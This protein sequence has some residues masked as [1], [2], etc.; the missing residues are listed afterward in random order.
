MFV[1]SGV[2][3]GD[4]CMAASGQLPQLIGYIKNAIGCGTLRRAGGTAVQAVAGL[5]VCEGDVVETAADARI[6]IHFIDGTVL[7]LSGDTCAQL[8]EFAHDC[9]GAPRSALFAISRGNFAFAGGELARSGS[10][11]VDTPVG[12]IR[13]RAGAG[14][15]GMLSLTALVFS[16]VQE[17]RAADPD[18][19]ILDDDRIPYKDLRHGV[20]E[21]ITKEA[22]P[23]HI[24]VE[25]P[26]ETIVLTQRGSAVSINQV[27]NSPAR[28]EELQ[29]AQQ[30]VLA[31][32]EKGWEPKGSGS[33]PSDK[34]QPLLQ[35]INFD[36]A[37]PP[38]AQDPLAPLPGLI[39]PPSDFLLPQPPIL[40]LGAGPTEIDTFAFDAFAT[41]SGT[42]L[43]SAA[44][45]GTL[46]FG[47][48]G[49]I[50]ANEVIGQQTYD[51]S[52]VGAFGTLYLNSATGAYTFVPDD[53]AI[54]ALKV[55]ATQSFMITVSDGKLSAS[56]SFNIPIHGADDAA[57]VSGITTGSA[58]GAVGVSDAS[59]G[60][61]IATGLLTDTDVDDPADTFTAVSSPTK[62]A[63]GY[64]S[65]TMTAGGAWTYTLD[66]DNGSVQALKVG[67]TLIDS[68]TVT[69]IGGT[70]QEV[71]VTIHGPLIGATGTGPPLALSET[72]LTA[73]GLTEISADFSAAFTTAEG[74][75][76]SYALT[77]TGGNGTA[78]GLVDSHTGLADV[79]VLNGGTIEGR[80]G[81]TSGTLAFTITVDPA[82]GLVTFTEYRAVLQPLGVAP[83]DG[84]SVSLPA[85][86]VNLVATL[87]DGN[88][89]FQRASLDLGSR[90]TITDDGP[91][92]AATGAAPSLVL[93]ET[94][95]PAGSVPA[96]ALTTA[97]ADFAAA[98]TSVQ[99]ADG[100]TTGYALTITGGD[101]TAWGL[102][103][104]HTGLADV[105]VLNGNTIE[106][107]VG[108][109]GG[110][111]AFTIALDPATGLVT[112]TEYRAV[113]QLLGTNPD[114]GEGLSLTAGLVNLVATITDTD[115]D[116]QTATLDLGTRL[117]ITDDGPTIG[118]TGTAPA[119][120]LSET[121][122][123]ATAL[124]ES[125]AGSAPDAAL[126][127]ISADFSSA[128]SSVQGADS[129]SIRY[130]LTIT[131]GDGTPS[132]LIDSHSGLAD[133][134]VLN[135]NTVE[136][137]VGS[138][139]GTLAF[140][141]A[142]DP[143]TGLVTFTEYRAVKQ[144]LGTNPDSGEGLSLT[145]GIVNLVA[146]IT[147]KDGD[148]QTAGIDLGKQ[149]T[150]TDDG[151]TIV[152]SGTAPALTLSETHLTDCNDD[153]TG[154]SPNA[155]L[156]AIS[157]DFSSAFASI[158]GA[159]SATTSYALAISCDGIASGLIDSHTGLSDVLIQNGNMIEGRVGCSSGALAFT[160]A[161][162]PATGLVTFTE[163]R[164][165][166]HPL[167]TDPDSG[168][169]TS[170]SAGIIDLVA[171]ITDKDG[172]FQTASIDL[173]KQLTITDDGPT[174]GG[175]K[176]EVIS[177]ESN[178]I[179][180][181]YDVDFGADGHAAMLLAVHNGAVGSTGFDLA[182]S[183]LGDGI[184]A[185]HVTGNDADYTFF[186]TTCEVNG[187]VELKAYL[188]NTDG[189]LTDPYFKLVISPDGTYCFD[190]Q[191][192]EVLNEVTV[193]GA[194][195][196]ASGGH[197]PSLTSPDGQLNITGSTSSGHPLDVKASGNGIA[198]GDYGL[199]MDPCEQ[200]DLSFGQEQSQVSFI[201]TQ[202]QGHGTAN[203]T[204]TAID[205]GNEVHCF[206]INVPKP[207]GDIANIVV[208]ET[209][210]ASLIDT[211]S[212]DGATSTYTLYVGHQFDQIQVDYDHAKS[213]NA[214]FTV[215]N[216][217]YTSETSVPS[218]DLL[219]DVSA[220]DKDGDSATTNLQVDIKG[221]TTEALTLAS[222]L[223]P[224]STVAADDGSTDMTAA[225]FSFATASTTEAV[226]ATTGAEPGDI[227]G[228][229]GDSFHFKDEMVSSAE[230]GASATSAL[231]LG[232]TWFGHHEAAMAALLPA[233]TAG[234][235]LPVEPSGPVQ[236]DGHFNMG[237]DHAVSPLM[238]H[239]PH[240]LIV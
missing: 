52:A 90:L 23:R 210:D 54:N 85:G 119:L 170:L 132:G 183:S 174:I 50:G 167:G 101:G 108:D 180:G 227:S 37:D 89:E 156:T 106:G 111:L 95:L 135:G 94:H 203:V 102:I 141:I 6:A 222:T 42:F 150:I 177:A 46:T 142:L 12:R 171:T 26:G 201:L 18:L 35:P 149:L 3:F 45:G 7:D 58:V 82:T 109:T 2:E 225:M 221:C 30:A 163:Y 17:A 240:D 172:D 128:F 196:A 41:A 107:R 25:D 231:D 70:P 143:A 63:G 207:S 157:A 88:G 15:F 39:I 148:F 74:G 78:S 27:T 61:L 16:F 133:V 206:N 198:V 130:A 187:G 43:A 190:L 178:P 93:S 21:L 77:I 185:V 75:T 120:T 1:A 9:S 126:T 55:N 67:D 123:T 184:T 124:N 192:T 228:T 51:V 238:T 208:Q 164:A 76:I 96:A 104:S 237:P 72:H 137:H 33:S 211:S 186:Y 236:P 229:L 224:G 24:I 98:F 194:D 57:I 217:T 22:V 159:D 53:H 100:A 80:V 4:A 202:W 216:I 165:V 62:S 79:L 66:N 199:Q 152:A 105:L 121:H 161:L 117:T 166:Q 200:L 134:L 65:F 223:A 136:G 175:F 125:I 84:E 83:G 230:A 213:G 8:S 145:A 116:S 64:G 110:T 215:N 151:P 68:F 214:T 212:Y 226:G 71:S 233:T 92:I 113:K 139:S 181:C 138:A 91:S 87:T 209:S 44:Q 13:G 153:V 99:G 56:Q 131:G 219:F 189:T 191:N 146:T 47:I 81:S 28:M 129:A 160:I 29:A 140:T 173:G 147:D 188:T 10:L 205:D 32:Y 204:F 20:F 31:N 232:T 5:P 154:S 60:L 168:E 144:P 48:G 169:G 97:S 122:L 155:A 69:T 239:V 34:T 127:A 14:G 36:P 73:T 234:A 38:A 40:N 179:A 195:F 162:D 220:V 86:L 59:P 112:F 114:S 235:A 115:G 176:H 19:T 218:T 103:D 193:T 11:A 49:G 118:T 197:T 182:T 158:Q